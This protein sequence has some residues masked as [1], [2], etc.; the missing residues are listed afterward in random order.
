MNNIKRT[1]YRVSQNVF[2]RNIEQSMDVEMN[3]PD[4]CGDIGS[5]LQCF[6]FPNI[7]ST[8]LTGQRLL[9]SGYYMIR[10]I[11]LSEGELFSFEQ[12]TDFEKSL[13][14]NA[15]PEGAI[16][17]VESSVQYI[18]CEALNSRKLS[19]HGVFVMH[20]SVED[21][22]EK[23]VIERIEDEAVETDSDL[24]SA[25]SLGGQADTVCR[26]SQVLDIGEG[27]ARLKSIL[28][29]SAQAVLLETKQ[30]EGKMLIKGELK[31][32]TLYK[33]EDNTIEHIENTMGIS[34]IMEIPGCKEDSICNIHM[35]VSS[36]SVDI[37]PNA[38]GEMSL[39]DIAAGVH[40]CVNCYDCID[41]PVLKDCYCTR[42]ASECDYK[43]VNIE[44][45]LKS[46]SNEY[47]HSFES[48][49]L[50]DVQKVIDIWPEE[51]RVKTVSS[52]GK[53]CFEGTVTVYVLY[54]DS[55]Q[56]YHLKQLESDFSFEESFDVRGQLKCKP[57][58]SVVAADYIL[59]EDR[60]EIRLKMKIE[61]LIFECISRRV[62]ESLS[63]SEEEPEKE[64]RILIY[65]AKKGEKLWDIAKKFHVGVQALGSD[66]DAAQTPIEE[67]RA[68]IIWK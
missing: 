47:M 36:L 18:N 14:L 10:V 23:D 54:L 1:E 35:R 6:A 3:L 26:L 20:I 27:K 59:R 51:P 41:F 42:C 16:I 44:K 2:E 11:Y 25:C 24:L 67:N 31:L 63:L 65:Y 22:V 17:N 62:V 43:S 5:V 53:L 21:S 60:L 39:L 4:Y 28:R 49:K 55:E 34:Q 45:I 40:I 66:K 29:N 9:I 68:L 32:K 57:T 7:T 52:D 12:K 38:D 50:G 33:S 61:A 64:N 58:A 15:P 30:V 46:F 13:E 37:K 56:N 19:A 8:V 48:E